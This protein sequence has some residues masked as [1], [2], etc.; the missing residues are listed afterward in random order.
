[1]SAPAIRIENLGKRYYRG[2]PG[3]RGALLAE[4]LGNALRGVR[5]ARG[6]AHRR[7]SRSG[8]CATCRSRS[9]RARSIGLIGP[10]RRRQEHAAQA[11][12]ADHAPDGGPNRAAR[13][14]RHAAR[15]RHGLPSRAHGP[16][17][18]LS[19]RRDPRAQ[20]P[21]HRAPLRRDRGLRG[22]RGLHRH[23][24]QALLERH[25]RAP[26]LRG[27]RAPRRGDH[28]RRRGAGGRRRRVPAQVHPEDPRPDGRGGA[29]D[30]VRQPQP[31]VGR[32]AMRPRGPHRARRGPREGSRGNGHG[33]LSQLRRSGGARWRRRD[34]RR[35][36]APRHRRGAL[37]Q[38][39]AARCRGRPADALAAAQPAA[40]RRGDLGG[41]RDDRGGR[42]R[43]RDHRRRRAAARHG[44]QHRRRR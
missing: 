25:V 44:A 34:P 8:R 9:P 35:S 10:E 31:R 37:S 29:D 2:A 30:R 5:R 39:P 19:E 42:L 26:R 21:G 41:V 6:T 20:P 23:P 3:I 16:R 15:G 13:P 32:A 27:R 36:A 40:D 24:G 22:R 38:R 28:V 1:M 11:P 4:R 43:G 17:E 33:R 12:V 14:R 7:W 18:R